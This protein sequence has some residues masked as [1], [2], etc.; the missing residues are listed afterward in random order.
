MSDSQVGA[1]W[2]SCPGCTFLLGVPR[3][4][5]LTS[6][7]LGTYSRPVLWHAAV[8]DEVC[9]QTGAQCGLADCLLWKLDFQAVDPQ[10]HADPRAHICN[11]ATV[12]VLFS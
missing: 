1:G 10:H 2:S 6:L 5:T 8:K 9:L 11:L 4:Q 12:H 3:R 7:H